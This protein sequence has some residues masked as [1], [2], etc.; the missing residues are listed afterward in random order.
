MIW[1][2]RGDAPNPDWV[3]RECFLEA[4]GSALSTEGG[5]GSSWR[6]WDKHFLERRNS[7]RKGWKWESSVSSGNANHLKVQLQPRFFGG[8]GGWV[9]QVGRKVRKERLRDKAGKLA[10]ADRE[11]PC[12]PYRVCARGQ[13]P[14]TNGF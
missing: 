6:Q 7:K 2:P 4:A 9:G 13:R 10:G 11:E 3:T 14:A 5:V 1:E 8:C 12:R